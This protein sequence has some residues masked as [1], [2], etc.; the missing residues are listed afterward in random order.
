MKVV[1]KNDKTSA[2]IDTKV[3]TREWYHK[4]SHDNILLLWSVFHWCAQTIKHT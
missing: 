2:W 4:S 3:I 1:H